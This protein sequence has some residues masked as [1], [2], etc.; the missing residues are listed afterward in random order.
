MNTNITLCVIYNTNIPLSVLYIYI[1]ITNI[2]LSVL[3]TYNTNI[4]I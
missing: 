4:Y 1:Y 3:C 2:P